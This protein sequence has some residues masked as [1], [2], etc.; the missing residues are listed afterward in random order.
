MRPI[1]IIS[2]PRIGRNQKQPPIISKTPMPRRNQSRR[3]LRKKWT[4]FAKL[5]RAEAF[6]TVE[7]LV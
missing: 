3:G 5:G 6:Q 4:G 7:L 2:S 1:G